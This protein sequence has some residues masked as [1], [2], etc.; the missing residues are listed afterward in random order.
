MLDEQGLPVPDAIIFV[1]NSAVDESSRLRVMDQKNKQ[2]LPSTLLIQQGQTV[3]F[4]NSDNIRH[5]VYSFSQTKTFELSLYGDSREPDV[6]FNQPGVVSLACNIHDQMKGFIFVSP[7]SQAWQTNQQGEAI[8][9]DTLTQA[10][11][12]HPRLSVSGTESVTVPISQQIVIALKPEIKPASRTF[13]SR[14]FG[15]VSLTW[16][17]PDAQF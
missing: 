15:D 12:W 1:A 11:V 10:S 14:S 7:G 2:F 9:P 3:R 17:R 6:V 13:G 16:N 5:H 4:P 8:I